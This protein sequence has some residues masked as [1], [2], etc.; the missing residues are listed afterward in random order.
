MN[1]INIRSRLSEKDFEKFLLYN[2]FYGEK[3]FIPLR[4]AI[5]FAIGIAAGFFSSDK[6]MTFAIITVVCLLVFLFFPWA[7]I[8]FNYKKI[9]RRNKS[10]AFSQSQDFEFSEGGVGFKSEHEN[11]YDYVDYKD[12]VKI[13]ETNSLYIITYSK[14]QNAVVSKAGIDG[15]TRKEIRRLLYTNMGER[16]I[17]LKRM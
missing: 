13:T 11:Y 7:Q 8:K 10:Q 16:Y 5:S 1:R 12:L 4:I 14:K 9:Y 17:K 3:Y 6:L 2:H 15:E